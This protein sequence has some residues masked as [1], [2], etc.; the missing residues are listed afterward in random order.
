MVLYKIIGKESCLE[1][2][3]LLTVVGKIKKREKNINTIRS[4][5][6]MYDIKTQRTGI[7]KRLFNINIP[8]QKRGSHESNT[9]IL[10]V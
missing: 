8:N 7:S 3:G 9:I 6:I 10:E 1:S 2:V 4:K 5:N